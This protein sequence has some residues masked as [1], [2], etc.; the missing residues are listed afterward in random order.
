MIKGPNS[1]KIQ[2]IQMSQEQQQFS[3]IWFCGD[4]LHLYDI[5]SV[6]VGD[7]VGVQVVPLPMFTTAVDLNVAS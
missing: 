3:T 2:F 4:I 1:E 6:A 7:V 5:L